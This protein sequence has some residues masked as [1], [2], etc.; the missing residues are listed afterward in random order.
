MANM[1]ATTPE[2]YIERLSDALDPEIMPSDVYAKLRSQIDALLPQL[3]AVRDELGKRGLDKLMRHPAHFTACHANPH[4]P[5]LQR[6]TSSNRPAGYSIPGLRPSKDAWHACHT[7]HK[8]QE[9]IVFL[10]GGSTHDTPVNGTV[11]AGRHLT[12]VA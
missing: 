5:G 9:A 3:Q 12:R 11:P 6:R 7:Y 4:V 2:Q 8:L 10:T 1:P